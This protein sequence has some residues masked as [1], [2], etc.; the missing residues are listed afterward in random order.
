VVQ[1]P[2]GAWP[3]PPYTTVAQTPVVREKPFLQVNAAG[4]FSVRVPELRNDS[5]GI[6][7][8]GGETAG[9]TIPIARFY[10]ARPDVD[11]SET[12]N[13]Q[14]AQGKDLI[15]TPGIYELTAPIRVTQPDT[16][17]L[18]LGFATLRPI[19]GTA[20]LTTAD[21]DGIK[22]AGLLFDAGPSESPVLLEVG[23]EGSRARHAKDPITLHDV[24]FSVGGAGIGRAKVNL[25]I[26]S[27]DTV[28]DH[29][30]IWRA[31]HGDGVGWKLNTSENGLVV[32]GNEVTIY[33]L[34]VEHHQ[35]FQV[36]WNGNGGRTYFYQSEIPY[37]PPNQVSYTSAPGVNGWASYKVAD[38]VT[39]HEAWGLG[40]YSVFIY[41]AVV[42]TRAIETPKSPQVRF[43][44]MITVALGDHGGI[45]HVIEDTGEA[46]SI[47]PR[48][49]PKVTDFP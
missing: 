33:G 47:H 3:S 39:S 7:W 6:T 29:T 14:L 4:E 46:T 20:A 30:W 21:A 44:D 34:F 28:V 10:I 36:L 45:S 35:Q 13:A 8:R 41:P 18:G 27:N 49:T 1:P 2:D 12:I 25:R 24:F 15:L 40:V 38:G 43:H 19:R 17:V 48:V 16:V 9:E 5:I 22:I 37:D 11:T 23:P 42:L 32:N 26:N 31:D